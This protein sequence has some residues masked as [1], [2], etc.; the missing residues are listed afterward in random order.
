[1]IQILVTLDNGAEVGLLQQM[2]ENMKWFLEP[3]AAHSSDEKSEKGLD[4]FWYDKLESLR[5]SY[6][7]SYIVYLMSF[8]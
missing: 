6:G 3:K 2:I 4:N 1:M 5:K 7:S 8:I